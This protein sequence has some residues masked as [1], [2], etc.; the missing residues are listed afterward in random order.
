[1]PDIRAAGGVVMRR[2]GDTNEV[3]IVH[4]PRYD[5]WS[6][7]KGKLDPGEDDETAAL[8]EVWEETAIRAQLHDELPQVSYQDRK[9]RHKV[10]RY[11]TMSV[12][13][14]GDFHPSHEVDELRWLPIGKAGTLLT[15]EH[16]RKL[17]D[18]IR[19]EPGLLEGVQRGHR[20]EGRSEGDDG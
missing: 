18:T 6:F 15:Y 14:A 1:M 19:Q 11:W 3:A 8:R 2:R 20:D 10:V 16:D 9:G 4:R 12:I 7:P 17:V 5:D 13:Q